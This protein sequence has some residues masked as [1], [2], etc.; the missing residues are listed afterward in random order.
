MRAGQQEKKA[1]MDLELEKF[2]TEIDL[3]AYAAEE[4]YQLDRKASWRGSAVM[5]HTNGDKIVIS[6]KPDGHYT[7]FSVRDNQ[8]NGTIIDFLA[9]RKGLSLGRIRKE[10]RLWLGQPL[11]AFPSWPE[12][13]KTAKD[14]SAAQARYDS[15][16]V[17]HRHPYLEQQRGIPALVLQYWRFRERIKCD[18]YSNVVFPHYDAAGLCGYELKNRNFTGFASG[19]SKGLWLSKGVP[20][21]KRLVICESAIDA[22]SHSVLFPD[23]HARYASI[24]GKPSPAQS[25]LLRIQ[26]DLMPEGSEILAAMDADPAGREL[27]EVVRSAFLHARGKLTFRSDEPVGHKDWNDALR[28]SKTSMVVRG[29]MLEARPA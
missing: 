4:G 25:G 16:R 20:E 26:I 28:A 5:R 1:G 23:S 22:L 27:S 14:R 3:R 15:M 10:L 2:K 12:L 6:R 7:Y 17:A 13:E 8:D 19:G 21:D 9:R 29:Y 24:G 11:S 18:R